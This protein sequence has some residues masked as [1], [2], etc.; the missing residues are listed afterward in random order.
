MSRGNRDESPQGFIISL[1]NATCLPHLEGA[2][3]CVLRWVGAWGQGHGSVRVFGA[4]DLDQGV[5][6]TNTHLRH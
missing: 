5:H 3:D 4:G 2:V 1:R 6:I